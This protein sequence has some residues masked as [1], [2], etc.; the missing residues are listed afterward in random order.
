VRQLF[1]IVI[2]ILTKTIV[3]KLI[4]SPASIVFVQPDFAEPWIN[5][6]GKTADRW[7]FHE[8]DSSYYTQPPTLQ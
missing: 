6:E 4:I 1:L 7:N 8:D 2:T 3:A 5:L